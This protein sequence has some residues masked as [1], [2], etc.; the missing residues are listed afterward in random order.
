MWH[1]VQALNTL[2]GPDG[3]TPAIDGWFDLVR[4]LTVRE[5]AL[6][7]EASGKQ[8]EAELKKAFGVKTGVPIWEAA[9][10]LGMSP[11]MVERTYGHHHPAHMQGAVDAIERHWGGH[12]RLPPRRIQPRAAAA[13]RAATILAEDH[14]GTYLLPFPLRVA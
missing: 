7:F 2:V 3:H 11:D 4:P 9:G 13:G 12:P 10:F 1:L 6:I 14:D 5:K 8:S